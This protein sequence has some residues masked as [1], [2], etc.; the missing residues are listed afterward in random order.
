MIKIGVIGSHGTRK[1]S[2]CYDFAG[3]LKGIGINAG[4]MEEVARNLPRFS[5]FNINEGTTR[6]SQQWIIH[7]QI[8]RELEYAAR[9]DID[10]LFT[11]RAV[12]DNWMYY[13]Y[14]FGKDDPVL[15]NYVNHW[16]QTYGLLVKVPILQNKS[17]EGDSVRAKDIAFQI[18]IDRL[19]ERELTERRISF[20]RYTT[21]EDLIQK[22]ISVY[23]GKK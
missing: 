20:E 15:D 3:K 9:G 2:L 1:T 7:S 22:V 21:T 4:V 13:L 5:G 18:G 14:K 16:T 6:E 23:E 19:L 8:K 12:I 10:L 11:D 17:L